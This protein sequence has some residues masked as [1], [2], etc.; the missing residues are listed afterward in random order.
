MVL[1]LGLLTGAAAGGLTAAAG[2]GAARS[3]LVGLAATGPAVA[4][5]N[6]LVAAEGSAAQPPAPADAGQAESDSHG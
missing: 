5:F 1:L 3:L 6:R 2:E 4:F